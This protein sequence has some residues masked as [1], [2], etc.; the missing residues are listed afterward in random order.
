MRQRAGKERWEE[1][2]RTGKGRKAEKDQHKYGVHALTRRRPH[3]SSREPAAETSF[4]CTR[5]L[6]GP[7]QVQRASQDQRQGPG[8]GGPPNE[9][10]TKDPGQERAHGRQGL[11]VRDPETVRRGGQRAM[12]TEMSKNGIDR[13]PGNAKTWEAG[14]GTNGERTTRA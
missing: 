14:V 8:A 1:E 13:L 10:R 3:A 7:G 2:E 12:G 9:P 11:R 4:L 5:I 6:L